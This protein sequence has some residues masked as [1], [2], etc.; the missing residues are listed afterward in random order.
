MFTTK[1]IEFNQEGRLVYAYGSFKA[2]P[3]TRK[4]YMWAELRLDYCGG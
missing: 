1:Y 4:L 3:F 2:D